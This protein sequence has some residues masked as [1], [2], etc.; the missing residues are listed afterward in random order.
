MTEIIKSGARNISV[1]KNSYNKKQ[2]DFIIG[3]FANNRELTSRNVINL[4][5]GAVGDA[6]VYRM[7]KRPLDEGVLECSHA[8]GKGSACRLS[9]DGCSFRFHLHRVVCGKIVHMNCG[10][11][12][13][14]ERH[15]TEDHGFRQINKATVIDG[16]CSKCWEG[17]NTK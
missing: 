4:A 10:E 9:D 6:A 15:R 13:E 16:F 11:M 12:R 7:L 5:C 17:K 2:R 14:A 3:L 1:R 8:D